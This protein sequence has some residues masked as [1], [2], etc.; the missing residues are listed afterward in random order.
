[1]HFNHQL[2]QNVWRKPTASTLEWIKHANC[3]ELNHEPSWC[4]ATVRLIPLQPHCFTSRVCVKAPALKAPSDL[5]MTSVPYADHMI[6][7]TLFYYYALLRFSHDPART[8][9]FVSLRDAG[10]MHVNTG[11]S[12]DSVLMNS[13]TTVPWKIHTDMTCLS[14]FPQTTILLDLTDTAGPKNL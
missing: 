6:I 3:T 13:V 1:M 8:S 12:H 14:R 10:W 9:G 5:C 4:E 11:S 7:S 2:T